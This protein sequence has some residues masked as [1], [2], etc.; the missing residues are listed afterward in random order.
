MT[1]SELDYVLE[2][3]L[4]FLEKRKEALERGK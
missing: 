2:I 1:L 4:Q 3:T